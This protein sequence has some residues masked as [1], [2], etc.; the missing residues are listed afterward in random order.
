MQCYIVVNEVAGLM[1]SLY[2][3]YGGQFVSIL[4]A[5]VFPNLAWTA[6]DVTFFKTQLHQTNGSHVTHGKRELAK[7][8]R[9]IYAHY[10]H[11]AT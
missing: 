9:A 3:A 11:S 4:D 2:K 6:D 10:N 1:L 8:L 7:A 5:D